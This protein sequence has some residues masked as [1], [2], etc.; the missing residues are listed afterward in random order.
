MRPDRV[1]IM[2]TIIIVIVSQ[3]AG[4]VVTIASNR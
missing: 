2:S 1:G 4:N 3:D